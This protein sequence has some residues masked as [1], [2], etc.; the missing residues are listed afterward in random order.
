[1]STGYRDRERFDDSRSAVSG[2]TGGGT[3]IT[4]Y[5]VK[6]DD[7]DTR[8]RYE[9]PRRSLYD[10]SRSYAA[11]RYDDRRTDYDRGDTRIEQTKII[12][13]SRDDDSPQRA[14]SRAYSARDPGYSKS[15]ETITI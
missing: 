8:S 1:M 12:R 5:V 10:D 15:R 2:R 3:K 7:Y 13:T 4:R 9:E 14:P 11:S 6:E